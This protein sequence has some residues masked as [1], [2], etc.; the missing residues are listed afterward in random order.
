VELAPTRPRLDHAS[1]IGARS[2]QQPLAAPKPRLSPAEQQLRAQL[3]AAPPEGIAVE[4]LLARIPRSRSWVF[5]RFHAL[6]EEGI[7]WQVRH[8]YWRSADQEVGDA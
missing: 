3:A 4:V 7:A 2:E 6:A 8:G 5:A 1:R